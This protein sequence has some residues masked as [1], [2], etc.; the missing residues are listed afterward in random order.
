MTTRYSVEYICWPYDSDSGDEYGPKFI[1]YVDGRD[2]QIN[3]VW[4]FGKDGVT[5]EVH[6]TE[7]VD[8][9]AGYVGEFS[10]NYLTPSWIRVPMFVVNSI[11]GRFQWLG[12]PDFLRTD[13]S[14][15]TANL[16]AFYPSWGDQGSRT[17][18]N[19]GSQYG[20]N[21]DSVSAPWNRIH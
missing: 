5:R 6:P 11:N 14:T 19:L 2:H 3:E 4:K 7:Q 17:N 1:R 12:V 10:T 8:V 21:N 15:W 13:G 18:P 16:L 20:G 9:G